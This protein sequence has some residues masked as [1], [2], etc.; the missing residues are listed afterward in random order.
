MEERGLFQEVER[1]FLNW[2]VNFSVWHVDT[3]DY[4]NSKLLERKL[5]KEVYPDLGLYNKEKRFFLD[6]RRYRKVQEIKT[7]HRWL[8]KLQKRLI[9]VSKSE[10]KCHLVIT[11]LGLKLSIK[12]RNKK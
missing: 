4:K 10:D 12:I 7:N 1:S 9:N 3:L 8:K 5:S 6:S 2:F 11:F